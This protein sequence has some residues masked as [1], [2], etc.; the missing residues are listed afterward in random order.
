[1]SAGALV[2]GIKASLLGYVRGMSDGVVEAAGGAEA[3]EGGF[4]FPAIGAG[5]FRGSVTLTGHHGMMR[6]VV[7]DPAIVET[8]EGWAVEI[9]DPDDRAVRLR[10][11]T[12]AAFD[13]RQASGTA[14]TAEGADLFFGPYTAGTALDDPRI[15]D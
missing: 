12:I 10:F 15:G 6:V 4:R 8:E 11:A 7:A 9:A 2:W 13:G 1:M 14:L 3:T 5:A